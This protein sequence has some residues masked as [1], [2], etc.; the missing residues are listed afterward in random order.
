MNYLEFDLITLS[1]DTR[2]DVQIKNYLILGHSRRKLTWRYWGHSPC[3]E[4]SVRPEQ[5]FL[6]MIRTYVA[7]FSCFPFRISVFIHKVGPNLFNHKKDDR[8]VRITLFTVIQAA[9]S[10]LEFLE[11]KLYGNFVYIDLPADVYQWAPHSSRLRLRGKRIKI[12]KIMK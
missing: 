11:F 8:F 4:M 6:E 12:S 10:H 1:C 3:Y 2:K 9:V 5:F 7:S